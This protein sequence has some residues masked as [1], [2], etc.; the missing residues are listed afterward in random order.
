MDLEK[1]K[2]IDVTEEKYMEML[3]FDCDFDIK[4]LSEEKSE[5]STEEN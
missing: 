2:I 4:D 1:M 5:Q 3:R